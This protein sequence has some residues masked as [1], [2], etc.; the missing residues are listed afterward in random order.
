MK[1]IHLKEKALKEKAL[2]E[3]NGY[4]FKDCVTEN[5]MEDNF[6]LH[7]HDHYEIYLFLE[8]DTQF[9]VEENIYT[10]EPHD[11]II[12]RKHE[13]HRICHNSN[14][15]YSRMN[16]KLMPDFFRRY[17]CEEYETQFRYTS[18]GLGHKIAADHV[19]VSGLYDAFMKFRKYAEEYTPDFQPP[20]FSAVLIEILYLIHKTTLFLP[21]DMTAN[22][23][24]SVISYLNNRY[25][26]NITL[27]MLQEHFFMSKY[28]LCRTF[29]KATGLTIHEY[30]RRKRLTRVRELKAEGKTIMEAALQVGFGNYSSFYRAYRKE[31]GHSPSEEL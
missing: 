18:E 25:A 11:M 20:V 12:V 21:A 10:L 23:M 1:G 31:Y 26:E 6:P 19:H 9:K 8:G 28:Y 14:T 5:I 4:F 7:N 29:H 22:P 24:R 13:M 15:R 17:H 27:D 30:L 3:K 16:V 2:K